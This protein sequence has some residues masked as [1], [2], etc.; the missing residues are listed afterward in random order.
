MKPT[1]ASRALLTTLLALAGASSGCST[2]SHTR[3]LDMQ[4]FAENTVTAIGEMRKLETPPIW[5]R[6][7][8]FFS[9]PSIV[10]TRAITKP[11]VELVRGVNS[12]SLQVVALNESRI[13]EKNKVRELV[14]YL[15]GASQLALLEEADSAEV[16]LTSERREQIFKEI[17]K[18]ESLMDALQ[19]ADPI[20]NAVL[21]RG[22][23]LSDAV[24]ASIM[25]SSAAIEAEVQ[26]EYRDVLEDRVNL[27]KLQEQT[28]RAQVLAQRLAFGD[29]AAAGELRTTVPFLAELLPVGQKPGRKE[30]QAVL[31]DLSAKAAK[32]KTALE[33]IDP[34][35]QAYRESILELDTLRAG[36][37]ENAKLAR[38][39]LM[40]WSRSHKS[41]A[42]GVEVPPMFDLA[43][44][45]SA[46]AKTAAT[47]VTRGAVPF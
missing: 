15:R 25:R 38:S 29:E 26:G 35:Y 33:Q 3:K 8:P 18:R 14:R 22:F 31:E 21:A 5:I 24:D 4:P 6:L 17:E 32:I 9:H 10:E 41:L 7:R 27:M 28:A 11:L 45:I 34:Q 42:R 36:K 43:G 19:A 44:I 46:S 20:V 12:Y 13:S 23:E 2:V 37:V 40:V 39:V 1:L 30:Q 16:R 47:T